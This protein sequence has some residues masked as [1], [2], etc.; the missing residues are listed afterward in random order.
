MVSD[1]PAA[2]SPAARSTATPAADAAPNQY[3]A[4]DLRFFAPLRP[5]REAALKCEP[6]T[7]EAAFA[8]ATATVTAEVTGVQPGRTY[9]GL[10]FL[11]VE[12]EVVEVLR[13][14]L[15]PEL[16]GVV[17]VEFPATFRPDPIEP[18][19]AAMR[20]Q[21]PAGPAV[22]LLRWQREPPPTRKPGAPADDPSSDKSLY[23]VVHPNCGVFAQGAR[24][25]LAVTA[26]PGIPWGAQHDGEQFRTLS[27]LASKARG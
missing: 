4:S 11:E 25:V 27:E 17:R 19:V 23:R 13:G 18:T 20:S 2:A 21:L 3:T 5:G 15:R 6:E 16:N 1:G 22:W 12:L 9:N 24:G 10:Q 8:E 7:L 14:A 26:R